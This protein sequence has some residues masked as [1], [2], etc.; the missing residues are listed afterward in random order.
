MRVTDVETQKLVSIGCGSQ[1]PTTKLEPIY[2]LIEE[3]ALR[4]P[5]GV[6]V[7]SGGESITYS[8]LIIWSNIIAKNL[9][10][11]GVRAN[12]RVGVLIQPSAAMVAATLG[13]LRCGATYVPLNHEQPEQRTKDILNDAKVFCVL[14]DE[15]NLVKARGYE[16]PLYSV[17]SSLLEKQDQLD[18]ENSP[19]LKRGNPHDPAYIIYT[20]GT[21]GEPKGVLVNHNQL[22]ASTVA[23]HM[24]YPGASTFL[25]LSPLAFDSS[26]AGLWG[27]LSAGGQLLVASSSEVRDPERLCFLIEHYD[28]NEILCVPS[29]YSAILDYAER[30][31]RKKLNSLNTVIVAG[32]SLPQSLVHQHFSYFG[33]KVVLINEYG[34]TETTVWATYKKFYAE[35]PVSIG[36]PIPGVKL[37]VL[38]ANMNLVPHGAQGELYIGGAQ[39]AEGYIERNEETNK[40]FLPDPFNKEPGAR[41][42]RTGDIVNWNTNNELVFIGRCDHQ[43]KIR[44]FRVELE[45]TENKLRLLP[46]I[47]DAVVVPNLTN[48]HLVAFVKAKVGTNL[49]DIRNQLALELPSYAVPGYIYKLKSF[50]LCVRGKIDRSALVDKAESF[51]EKSSSA[52]DKTEE[53]DGLLISQVKAAWT[54]V[55]GISSIPIDEN[56]FDVGGHSLMIFKLQLAFERHTGT[57]PSIVSL[58]KHT[59]IQAQSQMLHDTFI[60]QEVANMQCDSPVDKSRDRKA[61][62]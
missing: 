31:D 18:S 60:N 9:R 14:V 55:L 10:A 53:N 41:M 4:K 32:E 17:A 52:E 45:V 15:F 29:L 25:L 46:G 30:I 24:V 33:E 47:R 61:F 42:Y 26:V 44:G 34:P 39:V 35:G 7:I 38:D 50:P 21:A 51:I 49:V 1:L 8:E 37:Y 23:R 12:D 40:V 62:S 58:F 28:V 43:V 11:Q 22:A 57:R 19:T 56:F 54:D 16:I 5:D 48:T 36:K 3:V 2:H 27:T 20:S 6:A 59:T 13:V